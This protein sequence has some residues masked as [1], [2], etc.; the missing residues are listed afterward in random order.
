MPMLLYIIGDDLVIIIAGYNVR[1]LGWL[2]VAVLFFNYNNLSSFSPSCS[3]SPVS[4][5]VLV[6]D[7]S[8]VLF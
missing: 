5:T 4:V 3:S 8:K 2:L 1:L 7:V 6:V